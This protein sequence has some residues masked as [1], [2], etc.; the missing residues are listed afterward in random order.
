MFA[1]EKNVSW[2]IVRETSSLP[3]IHVLIEGRGRIEHSLN[4]ND[5][6]NVLVANTVIERASTSK[7]FMHVG[8]FWCDSA[9]DV[10]IEGV[11][12]RKYISHISDARY[13]STANLLT[14]TIFCLK[15]MCHAGDTIN[16][17]ECSWAIRIVDQWRSLMCHCSLAR[18]TCSLCPWVPFQSQKA[19]IHD[20]RLRCYGGW[21]TLII[22]C[23][24]KKGKLYNR[25]GN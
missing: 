8:D 7:G 25:K 24:T 10:L 18:C 17:K 6:G 9:T 14:E 23:T 19:S 16:L 1:T 2:L 4:V 12:V 22:A 5:I 21:C 11:C 20:K 3:C 13:I 15:Q